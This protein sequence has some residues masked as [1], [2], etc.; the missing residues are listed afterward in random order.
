MKKNNYL[1]LILLFTIN[2]SNPLLKAQG[3]WTPLT[4]LAPDTNAGVMLLLSDGTVMVK[5]LACACDTIGN[6]WDK[7]TPD[8]LGSYVNGK[9]SRLMPMHDTRFYFASQVLKDGRV[10][11][12]GGEYGSGAYTAETYDPLTDNWTQAPGSGNFFADANSEILE[13]G[14]VLVGSLNGQG[15]G[16]VIFNPKTNTWTNGPTCHG[17]HDESAWLKLPDKSILFVDIDT[18]NSE[19][20]IPSLNQWVVDATLPDSLYDPYWYESGAAFLLPDGR[21]FFLGSTGHTAYYT[22]SGTASPGAWAAGPDFPITFGKKYG[23]VDAAGAMMVNG[24]ILCAASPLNTSSDLTGAFHSPTAFYEFDYVSNAFT[25]I[26][27]PDGT[28]TLAY[29]P[30]YETNMLDLPDGT[31][32]YATQYSKQYY[33]YTPSGTALTIGK[34]TIGSI[35]QLNCDTF[36]MTGT[37]FNGISEGA[38]Y[39]DDWQMASNYPIIRLTNGNNVYYARSYNW[40]STSVQS[41]NTPDSTF[42]TIPANLPDATYSLAVTANGISSDPVLFVNSNCF[43][44]IKAISDKNTTDLTVYPNPAEEVFTVSFHTQTGGSYLIQVQDMFGRI[45]MKETAEA[46]AGDNI[47]TVLSEGLAKGIYMIAYQ[48]GNELLTAKLIIK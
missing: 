18:K 29:T 33:I 26:S 28:D 37:L 24:K 31:I 9:W 6:V 27:T 39:G 16:T 35:Q 44:G 1:L 10:F 21:A 34:P 17:S 2:F 11:V 22:P 15:N 7:L 38:G 48:K 12:A 40:N 46:L 41:G 23:T 36:R 30:C 19:R 32:L 5:S 20:Y 42:F 4:Q 47:H 13:D 25:Q 45:I 3:T 14:R 43:A 8:S